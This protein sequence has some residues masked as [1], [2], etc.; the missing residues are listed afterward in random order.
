MIKLEKDGIIFQR[1]SGDVKVT[2]ESLSVDDAPLLL[3]GQFWMLHE[4]HKQLVQLTQTAAIG[5]GASAKLLEF[6]QHQSAVPH[7][8]ENVDK[9]IAQ[10]TD[11][12]SQITGGKR[13]G[14]AEPDAA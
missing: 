9:M 12:L 10:V 5:S 6:A 8:D 4:I 11:M 13:D 3:W 7:Q 2:L 1:D 14:S